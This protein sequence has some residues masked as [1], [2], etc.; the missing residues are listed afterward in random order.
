MGACHPLPSWDL[1]TY[2]QWLSGASP[3]QP[4]TRRGGGLPGPGVWPARPLGWQELHPPGSLDQDKGAHV[5]SDLLVLLLAGKEAVPSMGPLWDAT[6][7]S[8]APLPSPPSTTPL[9]VLSEGAWRGSANFKPVPRAPWPSLK[10][11]AGHS[12][13]DCAVWR[14]Q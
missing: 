11:Q 9:L 6:P 4:G 5:G 13:R 1:D 14:G 10:G 12:Q 7:G 8:L 2:S 3:A